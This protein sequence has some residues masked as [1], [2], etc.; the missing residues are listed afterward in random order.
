MQPKLRQHP[1]RALLN[2]GIR[3]SLSGASTASQDS[4]IAQDQAFELET[5]R[6]A[7]L[8]PQ[9]TLSQAHVG[10]VVLNSQQYGVIDQS[11]LEQLNRYNTQTQPHQHAFP[12]D[13][14]PTHPYHA[15]NPFAPTV[16]SHAAHG[17]SH[18]PSPYYIPTA[19]LEAASYNGGRSMESMPPTTQAGTDVDRR[20]KKASNTT[21]ANEKEL[22]ELLEKNEH[23]SLDS[24]ARDVRNAERSQKSEKAKQLFAM[25]WSD[26]S[27]VYPYLSPY[28][29]TRHLKAATIL[30]ARSRISAEK[31]CI[32]TLRSTMWYRSSRHTQRSVFREARASHFSRHSDQ[33]AWCQGRIQIPLC[34]P[35]TLRR[36][37]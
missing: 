2:N 28:S 9:S 37:R 26:S 7:P 19:S 1:G 30:Q 27:P 18:G 22:R 33:K 10:D 4:S 16:P 20:D 8:Q 21:A 29:L 12:P 15:H 31:S 6:Y 17:M 25:R 11:A 34:E 32:Y 14:Q 24:I 3:R 13:Q 5:R 36:Q 23:R 35:D